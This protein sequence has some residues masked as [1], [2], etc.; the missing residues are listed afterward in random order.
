[1]SDQFDTAEPSFFSKTLVP[2]LIKE[3]TLLN[4]Q[5]KRSDAIITERI[6]QVDQLKNNILNLER[7]L[8][9]EGQNTKLW[10]NLTWSL[11]GVLCVFLYL[12][13]F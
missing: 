11:I 8:V 12:G 3:V 13:S 10:K 7:L 4:K 2:E 1:M 9:S 6:K 5:L